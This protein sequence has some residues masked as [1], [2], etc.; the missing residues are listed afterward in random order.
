MMPRYWRHPGD[1]ADA[2]TSQ[3]L[4]TSSP[5][6]K[7]G[8]GRFD[9]SAGF[10]LGNIMTARDWAERAYAAATEESAFAHCLIAD[11]WSTG[12]GE[13]VPYTVV[14]LRGSARPMDFLLDGTAILTPMRQGRTHEGFR[15]SWGSIQSRVLAR[16]TAGGVFPVIRHYVVLGHSKGGAEA[17]EVAL[18]I[19][20]RGVPPE[21]IH[22]Y[23]FG[24][25]RGMDRTRADYYDR[26]L[27]GRTCR[28][29]HE[30]DVIT[31]LPLPV[32]VLAPFRHVKGLHFLR[33]DGRMIRHPRWWTTLRSDVAGMERAW[34]EGKDVL[35]G[36]HFLAGYGRW[37][38][39]YARR[40]DHAR[41]EMGWRGEAAE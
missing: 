19:R 30:C 17:K 21:R 7:V 2:G 32:P 13:P 31:R 20:E 26:R 24:A 8:P 28:V 33:A 1:K 41:W 16:L 22:V 5:T 38:Q 27:P 40:T 35:L 10:S 23:T 14:G 34:R 39:T 6:N 36:D 11:G 15:V 12:P 37:L 18:A 25:P 4:L 29:V 3:S 9:L